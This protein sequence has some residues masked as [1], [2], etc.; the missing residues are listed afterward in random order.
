MANDFFNCLIN[1]DMFVLLASKNKRIYA[2]VLIKMF[3]RTKNGSIS[4]A[5]SRIDA[6]D[7]VN[8]VLSDFSEVDFSNEIKELDMEISNDKASIILNKLC[9]YGWIER[10]ITATEDFYVFHNCALDILTCLSN[11]YNNSSNGLGLYVEGII[12]S[13]SEAINPKTPKP[14]QYAFQRA[15]KNIDDFI[16]EFQ[17]IVKSYQ[18]KWANISSFSDDELIAA[19]KA[20]I[21]DINYGLMYDLEH[22]EKINADNK[23]KINE[24][25]EMIQHDKSVLN[26]I[27]KD[28]SFVEKTDE[29]KAKIEI[30]N[31]IQTMKNFFDRYEE[32]YK[33]MTNLIQKFLK[34]AHIRLK[35]I[36]A[37]SENVTEK[38]HYIIDFIQ[39][40]FDDETIGSEIRLIENNYFNIP[41]FFVYNEENVLYKNPKTRLFKE[42]DIPLFNFTTDRI[43]D[44]K[45]IYK[46]IN[47]EYSL[48]NIN[49][50]ILS[51]L[52][53]K[54][55]I[56]LSDFPYNTRSDV[57]YLVSII[58]RATEKSAKYKIIKQN[59]KFIENKD[60][61]IND[62][63]IRRR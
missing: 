11:L 58:I 7:D 28:M 31:K 2:N 46:T 49:K 56:N 8:Y 29:T 41:K 13:L 10:K 45:S 1:E 55:E 18:E 33:E 17:K 25:L 27:L 47:D 57:L 5:V 54:E 15:A 3:K 62:Y 40:N 50:D 60:F 4:A 63:K 21:D 39:R 24:L 6:I 16:G 44:M 35:N 42:N 20:F 30:L 36:T 9:K 32:L 26:R 43:S 61:K 59:D 38:L 12:R 22:R 37:N 53:D 14:Y 51:K 34:N 23:E 52:N 19:I 48:L